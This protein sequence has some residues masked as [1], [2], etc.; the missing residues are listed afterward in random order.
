MDETNNGENSRSG[1]FQGSNGYNKIYLAT[2]LFIILNLMNSFSRGEDSFFPN[3]IMKEI[4]VQCP[5][6]SLYRIW[7]YVSKEMSEIVREIRGDA[8]EI[9]KELRERYCLDI[10]GMINHNYEILDRELSDVLLMFEYWCDERGLD[11]FRCHSERENGLQDKIEDRFLLVSESV[12]LKWRDILLSFHWDESF[13]TELVIGSSGDIEICLII[14]LVMK[15]AIN[16]LE[17]VSNVLESISSEN[18]KW[19]VGI[20]CSMDNQDA[21]QFFLENQNYGATSIPKYYTIFSRIKN[22]ATLI[23]ISCID[24]SAS[25]LKYLVTIGIDINLK[26]NKGITPIW[27]ASFHG[28]LSVVKLLVSHGADIN[29]PDNEGITPLWIASFHDH[30]STVK[31]LVSLGAD[32]NQ[33]DNEGKTP[34]WI[35]SLYGRLSN[36][37]HL[38]SQGAD[39]H[40]TDNEGMTPL[41]MAIA[42]YQL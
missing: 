42:S 19:I 7:I 29:Q 17:R 3:E 31:Y 21:V 33:P 22:S 8:T 37:K 23:E 35:V 14:S 9:E 40:R 26:N 20:A 5:S 15:G 25:V 34:L 18:L 4:M 1:F 13:V 30:L 36:L 24:N 12:L 38:L 6:I 10:F 41:W 2:C 11:K 28:S 27:E 32:I 39:I 16:D